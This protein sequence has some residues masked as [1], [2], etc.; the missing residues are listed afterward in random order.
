MFCSILHKWHFPS[1]SHKDVVFWQDMVQTFIHLEDF[2][3]S[4]IIHVCH[5]HLGQQVRCAK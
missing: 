1:Y 5:H 2:V 4:V 3:E